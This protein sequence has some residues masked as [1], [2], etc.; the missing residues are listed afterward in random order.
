MSD[1]LLAQRL[2]ELAELEDSLLDLAMQCMLAYGGAVY[3]M[4]LLANAASNRTLALCSGFRRMIEERNGYVHLSCKHLF[5]TFN[6]VDEATRYRSR[7]AR[8]MATC[9]RRSTLRPSKRSSRRPGCSC[10]I[11]TDG[12]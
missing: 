4:D 9:R 10:G 1:D 7:S 2:A 3:P 8:Q 11:S 12:G 5:S 6:S